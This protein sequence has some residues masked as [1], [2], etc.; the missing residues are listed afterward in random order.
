MTTIASAA[1]ALAA[2]AA[3]QATTRAQ[4][5][6]V[7][8]MEPGAIP[9]YDGFPWWHILLVETNRETHAADLLKR[10][11]LFAYLPVFSRKV[12]A[13][14][15]AHQHRLFALIPGLLFVPTSFHAM[16]WEDHLMDL[17]HIHGFVRAAQGE[18]AR[19]SK[20]DI[21]RLREM[22]AEENLGHAEH[23]AERPFKPGD[24]ITFTNPTYRAF[25][26]D[27]RIK[28]V[29]NDG[30]IE[31]DVDKLFGGSRS[32]WTTAAKIEAK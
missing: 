22:E 13:R 23:P 10:F 2:I 24:E 32:V 29:A 11:N 8:Q 18:P 12:R 14:G 7:P 19:A 1:H 9:A 4:R 28:Q 30:R 15:K 31:V 20:A 16:G 5:R 6:H 21:E 27:G 17:C 26:G 25:L 3:E